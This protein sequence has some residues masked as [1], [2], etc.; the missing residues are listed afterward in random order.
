L[1]QCG[2]TACNDIYV[3]DRQTGQTQL[4]SRHTDGTQGNGHSTSSVIAAEGRYV[5]FVS[6]ATNLIANDANGATDDVFLHDLE[7]GETTL[8]SRHTQGAQGTYNSGQ[9]SLSADGHI[10]AFVSSDRQLI[11]GDTDGEFDRYSDIFV[12]DRA[13]QPPLDTSPNTEPTPDLKYQPSI[14]TLASQRNDGLQGNGDAIYPSISADARFIAFSSDSDNL[15]S[16]D[17]N[18][19]YDAFVY[20][21]QTGLTEMVSRHTDGAQG[22]LDSFAATSALSADGRYVVFH[23][24][25][26]DLVDENESEVWAD[27]FVHDRQTDRTTLISRHSNGARGNGDSYDAHISADGRHIAFSSEADNLVDEDTNGSQDVFVHDQETGETTLISRHS[28]GMQSDTDS[29]VDSISADGRFIVISSGADNLIDNDIT[30]RWAEVFVHDRTTGETTLISRNSD[31][32]QGNNISAYASVSADGRYVAFPSKADNLVIRDVNG[33]ADVFLHDRETGR[34][35]LISR[36]GDGTQGNNDSGLSNGDV[37]IS[38]DGRYVT[39]ASLADNLVDGDTNGGKDVFLYDRQTERTILISRHSNGT[40]SNQNSQAP[41]I[42]ADG[43]F[44]TFN[45]VA[46]NLVDVDTN[47]KGDIFVYEAIEVFGEA[48]LTRGLTFDNFPLSEAILV[49]I[50]EDGDLAIE[51]V[52]TG[53]V[54]RL[55]TSGDVNYFAVAPTRDRILLVDQG[56]RAQV[57]DLSFHSNGLLSVKTLPIP[58]P[59]QATDFRWA[60]DGQR[61]VYRDADFRWWITDLSGSSAIVPLSDRAFYVGAWSPDGQWVFYCTADALEIMDVSGQSMTVDQ[62][63]ECD[64]V[65]GG[66]W[67]RWSPAAPLLAYARG[68]ID[69]DSNGLSPVIFNVSTGE[70]IELPADQYIMD[71]S[72]N[73][74]YLALAKKWSPTGSVESITIVTDQGQVFEQL[75]GYRSDT[76]GATEWVRATE[77]EVI[78]GRYELGDGPD[79]SQSSIDSLFGISDDGTT[80]WWGLVGDASFVV[81]CT[82]DAGGDSDVYHSLNP[83]Y[84]NGSYPQPGIRTLLSPDGSTAVID[85]Y[86]GGESWRRML[87]RCKG[88]EP[89]IETADAR[90]LH[91]FSY[92]AD[93]QRILWYEET[94]GQL[95]P[96]VYRIAENAELLR[97]NESVRR[98]AAWLLTP[99]AAPPVVQVNTIAGRVSDAEGAPLPGARLRLDGG[100]ATHTDADGR[101]RFDDLADGYYIVTADLDGY[102]FDTPL[103]VELPPAQTEVNFVAGPRA[104]HT[105]SGRVVDCAAQPLAGVRVSSDQG[106]E[107]VTDAA[108]QYALTGLEQTTH[109]ITAEANGY[110]FLPGTREVNLA[111]YAPGEDLTVDFTAAT[112]DTAICLPHLEIIQ[113]VQDEFNSAPLIAGKPAL[114]RAYGYCPDCPPEDIITATLEAFRMDGGEPIAAAQ[115]TPAAERQPVSADW[116]VQRNDLEQSF[117]FLLPP[118]WLEGDIRFR[119]T[120]GQAVAEL[121]VHFEPAKPLTI[122]YTKYVDMSIVEPISQGAS[123]TSPNL[124]PD[125]FGSESALVAMLPIAMRDLVYLP[126]FGEPQLMGIPFNQE[127]APRFNA[128]RYLDHLNMMWHRLQ[129][130]GQWRDGRA[131]DRLIAWVYNT[132]RSGAS[133]SGVADGRFI[134]G[135]GAVTA[136]REDFLKLIVPGQPFSEGQYT[137]VHELG[138]LLDDQGLWHTPFHPLTDS[139]ADEPPDDTTSNYPAFIPPGSA[140]DVGVYISGTSFRLLPPDQTYDIM[141]YCRPYWISLHNYKRLH[142]GFMPPGDV[143]AAPLSTPEPRLLISGRIISS[144]QTAELDPIYQVQATVPPSPDGPGDACV[145]LRDDAN[146]AL[147]RRCFQP[148]FRE[149]V[150]GGVTDSAGFNLAMPWTDGV[151][152]VVVTHSGQEM[153]RLAA[154]AAPP[155][156]E[157][158]EWGPMDPAIPDGELVVRWQGSDSDGDSLSYV[159]SLG[160]DDGQRWMPVALDVTATELMLNPADLP[161]G[162]WRVRVEASDGFHSTTANS[163]VFVPIAAKPPVVTL[164]PL[165]GD[166]ALVAGQPFWLQGS[167]VDA[168]DGQLSAES[169]VW[170]ADNGES[171]G[172]GQQVFVSLPTGEHTIMLEATDSNGQRASAEISLTVGDQLNTELQTTAPSTT[173]ETTQ[174][175]PPD[176]LRRLLLLVMLVTGLLFVAVLGVFLVQRQ[177]HN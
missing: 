161:G 6:N 142:Q 43:K 26:Y 149:G 55:T 177:R 135:Y 139:C 154:S 90:N 28:N 113:V 103:A 151:T 71:W 25:A 133:L 98:S 169:L 166:I 108:G 132:P 68:R 63:I 129:Q 85:A 152:A 143:G 56:R 174:T 16:H 144:T 70:H 47:G 40:Q 140:G 31:G 162:D 89:L 83:V 114:L 21:R 64:R 141:T 76:L 45:S 110:S 91:L 9:P 17:T 146:N 88:G 126:Q 97:T 75:P 69:I 106:S 52:D 116:R 18:E 54:A 156:V 4:V 115:P 109:Q 145:E 10:V 19:K 155:A 84:P 125:P 86:E 157:I 11:D 33:F 72:P 99:G 36:H 22:N 107:T 53:V 119:V 92:S 60:P 12:H 96:R 51:N 120:I 131:P 41:S 159:V 1:P 118:E 101:Y 44:V 165:P 48:E 73:G 67:P 124:F 136:L 105:L 167:A 81:G 138:H 49:Y 176:R 87:L 163:N 153:G 100:Q 65:E 80:R 29:S 8:I 121:E 58:F 104:S 134:G 164:A 27:I 95:A 57:M 168:E 79:Q 42:S 50:N 77:E 5:A 172:Q 35:E 62:D 34:T 170:Y 15:V 32:T 14:V 171:L 93:S 59:L 2:R 3:H 148:S 137:L 38:A 175:A 46:D 94:G 127:G 7:T 150:T 74:Q 147:E 160:R 117:N 82:Q 61:L 24:Q 39:Y 128:A 13:G 122:Y 20:D 111:R 23:S 130:T 102:V 37:R 173:E 158:E 112:D 30:P 66:E 123:G 78:F